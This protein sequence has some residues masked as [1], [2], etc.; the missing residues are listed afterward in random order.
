VI[1]RNSHRSWRR[2][3][4]RAQ[5]AAVATLLGLLLIVTIIASYLTTQ[6]PNQMQAND[7]DHELAVENQL[8]RAVALLDAASD[9]NLAGAQLTQ[10]LALGS[11]GVPPFAGP[12]PSYLSG[13]VNGTGGSISYTTVGTGGTTPVVTPIPFGAG[14]VDHLRNTYAPPAEIA[15]VQGAV[16]Y[17]QVAG[18]PLF[19]DPPAITA[20]VSGG[21]VTAFQV[22][23]PQFT[24]PV[25][26]TSGA[27]TANLV[28]RLLALN[29]VVVTGSNHLALASGSSVTLS[30]V[31]QYAPA[32]LAYFQSQGWPG[33]TVTCTG[34]APATTAAACSNPYTATGALGT[35]VVTVPATHIARLTVSVATFSIGVQ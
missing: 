34:V 5:V 25:P 3:G 11:D 2:R 21:A 26:G 33:V 7:L 35:I 31:S 24:G 20:T 17:A 27:Y 15:L 6:L 22:W 19:I 14:V 8:G 18:T 29:S 30:L 23:F 1:R 13:P 9:A 16:V 28:F 12:D 32:W 10:P 4:R